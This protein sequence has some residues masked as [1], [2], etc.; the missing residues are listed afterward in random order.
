M[1]YVIRKVPERNTEYLEKLL[2]EAVVVND[3]NYNGA[4][5]SLLKAIE[6]ANDDAIYIQ[7]DMLLSKDFVK[8]ANKYIKK[9]PHSVIVFSYVKTY[10]FKILEE[11]FYNGV[12]ETFLLCTYIPK[13]IAQSFRKFMLM[14]GYKKLPR[15]EFYQSIQADDTFFAMYLNKILKEKVFVTYPNLAGHGRQDS[16]INPQ[17]RGLRLSPAFDYSDFFEVKSEV[18]NKN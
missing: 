18:R 9:Y 17:G 4:I 7:D 14:E 11:G 12:A 16:V 13:D 15:Y 2:P 10:K 3:V 1:K 6:Q 8:S 5:W